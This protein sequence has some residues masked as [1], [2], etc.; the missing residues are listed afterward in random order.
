M[1]FPDEYSSVQPKDYS[2]NEYSNDAQQDYSKVAVVEDCYV[3]VVESEDSAD[4]I[5]LPAEKDGTILLSTIQAQFQGAT[6]LKYKSPSGVAWRGVRLAEN[7]LDAPSDGWQDRLYVVTISKTDSVK[8][9]LNESPIRGASGA[10]LVKTT[11]ESGERAETDFIVLGLSWK[12]TE[13]DLKTYFSQFGT[14]SACEIKKD[15]KTGR[16]RG[17][18][19]VGL[20]DDK[21]RKNVLKCERHTILGREVQVTYPRKDQVPTK[22]FVGRLPP[23][24]TEDELREHFEQFGEISDV[25]LPKGGRGFAFVT[26]VDQMDSK[27]CVA[28]QHEL[29]ESVLNVTYAIPKEE[30]DAQ[31][32]GGYPQSSGGHP[33]QSSSSSYDSRP[34]RSEERDDVYRGSA[35]RGSSAYNDSY[36]GVGGGSS[37]AGFAQEKPFDFEEMMKIFSNPQKMQQMAAMMSSGSSAP[38]QSPQRSSYQSS[39]NDYSSRAT[40]NAYDNAYKKRDQRGG[41]KYSR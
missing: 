27:K 30:K 29:K 11:G 14:I 15:A 26:F 1:S 19:F 31:S 17:F 3:Q 36:R 37:G 40:D 32:S 13:D 16:S 35:S 39:S 23:D 38:Q 12:A 10:K 25:Y 21:G 6:G 5:E 7:K 33:P 8:R 18:G 24:T 22:I 28:T 9:K 41:G 34:R 4:V 2:K 20:A